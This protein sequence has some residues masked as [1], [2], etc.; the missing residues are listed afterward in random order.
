MNRY[1]EQHMQI[2]FPFLEALA[3]CGRRNNTVEHGSG[4]KEKQKG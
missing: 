3:P 1:N 4:T 2:I